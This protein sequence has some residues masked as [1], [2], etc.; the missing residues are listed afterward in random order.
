MSSSRTEKI[1]SGLTSGSVLR[2]GTV[3]PAFARGARS[4]PGSSSMNMSFS[5]VFGRSSA[6]ASVWTKPLYSGSR[7]I[8]TTARPSFRSTFVM[9]PTRTPD[10]RTVWPWPGVTACAVANSA[11]IRN[12]AS[13]HG[14]RRRWWA[15]T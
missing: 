12:G 15:S 9:S 13:S 7:S 6:L 5:P 1:S 14:N 2:T 3:Q 4:V 10:T 11:L 8:V